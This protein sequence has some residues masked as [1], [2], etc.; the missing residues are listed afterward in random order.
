[1]KRRNVIRLTSLLLAAVIVSVGFIVKSQQKINRYELALKN[2]YA[3]NLDDFSAAINNISLTLNKARFVTT[4][5]QISSMAA[6]LLAEAEYSK[7]ALSQL[8]T[9]NELG[10]LNRF[11]SQVGNY[12][13]SVSGELIS[14]GEI[15]GEAK[16]NIEKLSETA[17]KVATIVS[18]AQI[19]FNNAEYWAEELDRKVG[20]AVE[21]SGISAALDEIEDEFSDYPTLVYD[22]PYSDHILEK[23]PAMIKNSEE[24]SERKALEAAAATVECETKDLN[25][26]GFVMGSIPSYRFVGNGV[27][28]TVSKNGGHTVF[29]RKDRQVG[30]TL[31]SYEQAREK[32]K[33]YL[34]RIKMNNLLE[35]YYF[36]SE[37]V[38]VVNFAF[39]DGE[40]IC[41]TDLIK[42]GVA[43]DNGEIM[44][45]E[46]SGYISNHTERAFET[47]VYRIDQAQRVINE[48]LTVNSTALALIPTSG[49][50]EARC[51]E[52][53]CTSADGQEI[54]VYINTKNMEEEEDLIL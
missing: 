27:T 33:R 37:G 48:S 14:N 5:Q 7:S 24:V 12:A 22:G 28:A 20:E 42:V 41:Y 43:M 34:E 36:C 6:K 44:L 40:T 13:M 8:P 23:E 2:G 49:K 30:D 1:M 54:L 38:C 46:A 4:P 29:M 3:K 31:L 9:G 35:T 53:S 21:S 19:A 52:F 47:P 17:T 10:A 45:Y 32:A 25:Y 26:D 18:D 16:Q 39:V 51:Y 11:L 50:N 15:N